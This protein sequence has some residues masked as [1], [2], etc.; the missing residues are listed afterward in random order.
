MVEN[1]PPSAGEV[2]ALAH[3][4]L[5]WASSLSARPTLGPDPS[6]EEKREFALGLAV[7]EREALRLR[8]DAFPEIDL[9]N[10]DWQIAVELYIQQANGYR[11]APERLPLVAYLPSETVT[12]ALERLRRADVV[13][14]V[15]DRDDSAAPWLKLTDD[16]NRR[17]TDLL[18]HSARVPLS[19]FAAPATAD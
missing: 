14:T 3:Q 12:P 15:V 13:E 17:I 4:L 2:R 7:A 16:G 10:P 6:D 5:S 9:G 19:P 1:A 11:T 18:L 8:E